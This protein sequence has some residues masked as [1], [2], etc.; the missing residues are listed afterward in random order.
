MTRDLKQY[1]KHPDNLYRRFRYRSGTDKEGGAIYNKKWKQKYVD[2][3]G[4]VRFR[5]VDLNSPQHKTGRGVYRSS[6]KNAMRL[7]RTEINMAY[8]TS[9]Y[10]RW[11][12]MD[13]VVGIEVILSNN[14]TLNGKPF[15]DI[16]D[17]LKGKYPKDFKFT[18]WHPQCRCIAV[19]IL[20]EED[21]I[22]AD[23]E[24]IMDGEQPSAESVNTV[25]EV[26]EGYKQWITTNESRIAAAERRGT[27][28]Y[29]IRD[30]KEY[31]YS[32]TSNKKQGLSIDTDNT[33]YFI[34]AKTVDTILQEFIATLRQPDGFSGFQYDIKDSVA[35]ETYLR[36]T[37]GVFAE[38][39]TKYRCAIPLKEVVVQSMLE[40]GEVFDRQIAGVSYK[41]LYLNGNN[42]TYEEIARKY[43]AKC[44]D[45]R[46]KYANGTH[47]FSH[48]MFNAG[49]RTNK[50]WKQEEA[51][52][53][54]RE[55]IWKDYQ[56]QLNKVK[57]G[58]RA[59]KQW[60]IGDYGSRN[61][62]DFQAECFSEYF[63]SS[64]PSKYAKLMGKLIDKYFKL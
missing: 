64:T 58:E 61:I 7:A 1:L 2:D 59:S 43:F 63:N 54:E 3:D 11:Q 14:H 25:T 39:S 37:L 62:E 36:N 26:P 16:C 31:T 51:Y 47:E 27:L 33:T 19:S 34:D 41:A 45:V 53:E 57:K 24:A 35:S 28:P 50:Y 15:T 22:I 6:Y 44:D 8:H 9:D 40:Y 23:A 4:N 5:D 48:Y 52:L 55:K 21:E 42:A 32:S 17:D 38:L 18:G 56:A 29:F 10:L 30:N 60:Y 12:Q 46:I 20:K 13:F 49:G